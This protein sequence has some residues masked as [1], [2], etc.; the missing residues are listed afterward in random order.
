MCSPLCK[1]NPT[2]CTLSLL[3]FHHSVFLDVIDLRFLIKIYPGIVIKIKMPKT[4][5]PMAAPNKYSI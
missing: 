3:L 5:D 2:V 1:R 4:K